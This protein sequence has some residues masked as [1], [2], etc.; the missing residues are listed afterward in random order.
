VHP[1]FDSQFRIRVQGA[2]AAAERLGALQHRGLAG[3]LRELLVRELLRPVVP[4]Y[5]GFGTGKIVDY[6]GG[7]SRQIDLIIYDKRMMPPLL[8]AL[9]EP[10]GLYPVEACMYAIE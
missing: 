2:L 9:D 5:V 4:D 1:V 6:L 8:F 10:L 7:E 3:Q